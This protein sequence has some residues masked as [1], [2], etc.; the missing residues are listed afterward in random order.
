MIATAPQATPTQ[1]Q[2][3]QIF[4]PSSD[5]EPLAETSLH[6]DVIIT[7]VVLLRQYLQ[8]HFADRAPLILADQFVY[9]AE[10]FPR[11]RF[12]PD[13]AVIFGV[14]PGPRDN[15]KIWQEKQVPTVIFEITSPGT[16]QQ[17]QEVKKDLYEKIGV[18]EYWLFDPKGEW[19][20]EQLRG[21]RLVGEDYQPILDAKSL[22]L[23]LRFQ[24]EGPSLALYQLATGEKLLTPEEVAAARQAEVTARQA[25]EADLAQAQQRAEQLAEKLRQLGIDPDAP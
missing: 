20:P 14:A 5:G 9:Y 19:I 15:Y 2:T 1:P 10:N 3:P 11:L 6:V 16:Q 7:L 17:D 24:I 4:Y 22:A 25:A 18:Q 13:V 12:A 23:G 8:D 21:Y